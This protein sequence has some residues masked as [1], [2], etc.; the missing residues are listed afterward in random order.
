MTLRTA[1]QGWMTAVFLRIEKLGGESRRDVR[2]LGL[3]CVTRP[4]SIS[5]T[6]FG[7]KCSDQP[8][9]LAFQVF[10]EYI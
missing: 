1:G 3:N 10:T 5:V 6:L 2:A 8:Q 7:N 9:A 4:V